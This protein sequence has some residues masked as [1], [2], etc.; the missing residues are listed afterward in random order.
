MSVI[1][2]MFVQT[3]RKFVDSLESNLN[4]YNADEALEFIEKQIY[5]E[6]QKIEVFNDKLILYKENKKREI[7]ENKN[8]RLII[9][10]GNIYF[11][12]NNYNIIAEQVNEFSICNKNNVIFL[13]IIMKGGK[14][15]ER[16]LHLK[17]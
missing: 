6:A 7:I 15:K 5:Y 2:P 11:M 13:K 9:K 14:I 3:N 10:Y 16:C 12:S 4:K 1:G 8:G 17:K